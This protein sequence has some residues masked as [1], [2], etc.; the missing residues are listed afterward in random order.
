M[1][2]TRL[3]LENW[4]NFRSLDVILEQRVFLI[5][6]NASGK[7]NFLDALRFL[8][9]VAEQGLRRA[10]ESRGGVSRLR[11]LAARGNPDITLEVTLDNVWSYELCF[12]GRK[13]KPPQVK[14]EIVRTHHG[15]TIH[16]TWSDILRRPDKWDAE[17]TERLTQT[18][19]EQ[20]NAN[21]E[22]R[23]I[24][25]FL[26]T[27]AYRHILPQAVKDPAGFT[28]TPVH[29]D[30]FGRD[31]IS[32]IWQ[33]SK[34]KR[35][36]LLKKINAALKIAVPQLDDLKVEMNPS[37]GELH[38]K[39]NY[40]HW[41]PPGAI[42]DESSFSD[43]TLRLLALLWSILEGGG[44]LLL[45]E[46]ELSLHEEIVRQLPTL[47]ASLEMD[48]DTSRQV[49]IS[50]HSRIMLLDQGIGQ[51]EVVRLL[52][53]EEGTTVQHPDEVELALLRTGQLSVGEVLLPRTT[54]EHL[55][56]LSL[57]SK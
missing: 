37:T 3:R 52:P 29:N 40:K 12:G 48:D 21:K 5:G 32:Q 36:K 2:I 27:I 15:E 4:K 45:E 31:F 14:R 26:K 44:P 39:V 28:P 33:T 18:A 54:P 46:P 41:R 42:Q 13:G 17:D 22:F 56:Q 9:D 47:F 20:V 30:P 34:V 50:T 10:V 57:F 19:L 25:D 55:E 24:P 7:S 53:S 11:C 43:G 38:L 1:L 16:H 35:E 8:R 51:S 23:D 6:P 49:M